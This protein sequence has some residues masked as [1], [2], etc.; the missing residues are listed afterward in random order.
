[1]EIVN[2][3]IMVQAAQAKAGLYFRNKKSWRCGLSG[4][5]SAYQAQLSEFKHQYHKKQTNKQT[6]TLAA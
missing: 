3:W 1:M 2:K 6:K 5:I 4:G